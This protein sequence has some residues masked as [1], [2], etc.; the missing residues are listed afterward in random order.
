MKIRITSFTVGFGKW[1]QKGYVLYPSPHPGTG[2]AYMVVNEDGDPLFVE[3]GEDELRNLF[4]FPE[5]W[6][7]VDALREVAHA[8]WCVDCGE[9]LTEWPFSGDSALEMAED[10]GWLARYGP[11]AGEFILP[12][13]RV[14][15]PRGL[16]AELPAALPLPRVLRFLADAVREGFAEPLSPWQIIIPPGPKLTAAELAAGQSKRRDK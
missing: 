12:T 2:P 7:Y 6:W 10:M 8:A 15:F 3:G 13:T 9:P 1:E 4:D 14:W 16:P 5:P 11:A